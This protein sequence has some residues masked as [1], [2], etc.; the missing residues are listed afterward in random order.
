MNLSITGARL[1]LGRV[2]AQQPSTLRGGAVHVNLSGQQAN[3]LLHDGQA[4]KEFARVAPG[5]TRRALRAART[6]GATMFV[7]ASFAFVHAVE[8][9]AKVDEPL[10]S[11][12]DS[13][14]ECEALALSG[15]LPACVVRLGYLY[16]PESADLLAYRKAF[17]LGRPYWSGRTAARQYHV[18]QFDAASALRAAARPQNA[19]R[20]CYATDGHAISFEHFMDAFAQRVGRPGPLH[21]PLVSHLLAR[22]I[23][24]EEHM[25]QT[26]LGM[27]PRAPS[28][29][30]PG[31]KPRFSDYRKGLDQVI[32][33]W[34]DQPG[35]R[36]R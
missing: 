20:T 10:R 26:A 11:C 30:V 15:P 32:E 16:G 35:T 28:P 8:R 12:V 6:A 34:R 22:V 29:R 7:H 13:I 23:I 2:L 27:P 33:T 19:G 17:R 5:A 3:T 24:R 9:G 18:H 25:Q 31:W 21:L 14:L 1:E 36:L 4:W